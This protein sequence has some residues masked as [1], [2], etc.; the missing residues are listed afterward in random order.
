MNEG[1][2]VLCTVC[3]MIRE[4]KPE[5]LMSSD[6]LK[7][8]GQNVCADQNSGRKV[9]KTTSIYCRPPPDGRGGRYVCFL[10]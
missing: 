4:R 8:L 9:Q 5:A 2:L 1:K 10:P 3:V 6:G 7:T